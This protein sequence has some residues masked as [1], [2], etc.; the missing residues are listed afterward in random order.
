VD[1]V[2]DPL[3]LRKSGIAGNRTRTSATAASSSDQWTTEA[4]FGSMLTCLERLDS[5]PVRASLSL[6]SVCQRSVGIKAASLPFW[7]SLTLRPGTYQRGC[8]EIRESRN[9]VLSKAREFSFG[10]EGRAKLDSITRSI[11][12]YSAFCRPL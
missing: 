5:S 12:A 9:K 2:P 7:R 11:R 1:P 10:M 3:L 4:A 8:Y 6:G